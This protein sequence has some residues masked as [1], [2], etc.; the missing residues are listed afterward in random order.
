MEICAGGDCREERRFACRLATAAV[1]E[2]GGLRVRRHFATRIA[3][4]RAFY[5]DRRRRHQSRRFQGGQG[6]HPVSR[7]AGE[8]RGLQRQGFHAAVSR[9]ALSG[10]ID[11]N[12]TGR[13]GARRVSGPGQNRS[14]FAGA[15][16]GRF[17][18]NR[19]AVR[20]KAE[21]Y[22][23]CFVGPQQRVLGR[24]QDSG[25]SCVTGHSR[26][27]KHFQVRFN[28]KL[29]KI[30]TPGFAGWKICRD[31]DFRNTGRRSKWL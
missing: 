9:Q 14:S 4:S 30:Y 6:F 20:M 15:G 28:R 26:K 7:L 16:N 17:D 8:P 2:G 24:N 29:R 21:L 19:P 10:Q 3:G 25:K 31:I 18:R 23:L 13:L 5:L 1:V 22:I 27:F 11:P 12:R